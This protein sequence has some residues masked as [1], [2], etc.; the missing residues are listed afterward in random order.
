MAREGAL[1]GGQ[2]LGWEHCQEASGSGG[3]T[4]RRPVAQDPPGSAAQGPSSRYHERVTLQP[5][6]SAPTPTIPTAADGMISFT[7]IL[8]FQF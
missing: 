5:P 8:P 6:A 3:S 7:F 4:A 2:W 1:P